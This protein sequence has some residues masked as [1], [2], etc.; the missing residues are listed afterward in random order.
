MDF[1][2]PVW[3]DIYRVPQDDFVRKKWIERERVRDFENLYFYTFINWTYWQEII[4]HAILYQFY[5]NKVFLNFKK[6]LEELSVGEDLNV[7]QR[8]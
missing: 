4:L 1:N 7:R 5:R 8:L 2:S 3:T 6:I